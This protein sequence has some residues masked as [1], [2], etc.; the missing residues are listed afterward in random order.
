MNAE[1]RLLTEATEA[2]EKGNRSSAVDLFSFVRDG[3]LLD[4]GDFQPTK[5]PEIYIM[6]LPSAWNYGLDELPGYDRNSHCLRLTTNMDVTRDEQ[7][8]PVGFLGRAHPL[9]RRAVDRVRNLSFGG[10][11]RNTQD[12]R[13]SVVKA[14]VEKPTLLFTFLGRV[15]SNAGSEFEK[16]LAV[17]VGSDGETEFYDQAQD[18]LSLADPKQ[19]ISTKNVWKNYFESCWETATQQAQ[20]VAQT[21]WLSVAEAFIKERKRELEIE[22]ARQTEWLQQ[23]SQEI[24][25]NVENAVQRSGERSK[26][27]VGKTRYGIPLHRVGQSVTALRYLEDAIWS[28]A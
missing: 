28:R 1:Q 20:D 12:S 22:K 16:V 23:R 24:T 6:R 14:D 19:A 10:G 13:V 18:W 3:I 2:R 7:N 17:K 9:V 11:D 15:A 8:R 25:G 21:N 26:T 27:L 5:H 4:G